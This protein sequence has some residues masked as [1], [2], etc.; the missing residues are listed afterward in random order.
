MTDRSAPPGGS[1]IAVVDDD[2]RVLESLGSL[3]ESADHAVHLFDSAAAMLDSGCLAGISCLISDIDMPAMDGFALL[4]I[5]KARRPDLAVILITGQSSKLNQY[6][7]VDLGGYRL[8]K[9]PFSA[10]DLLSTI[11]SASR[12]DAQPVT[13]P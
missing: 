2:Q 5:V 13:P 9:K 10:H 4:G 7:A 8:L 3:L 11:A 6:R 1:V 12:D